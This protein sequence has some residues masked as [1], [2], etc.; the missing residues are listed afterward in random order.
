MKHYIFLAFMILFTAQLLTAAVVWNNPVSLCEYNNV[1]FDG[2]G[3]RTSD[4]YT[5]LFWNDTTSNTHRG[6]IQKYSDDMVPQWSQPTIIA[7]VD[8][9]FNIVETSDGNYLI[10]MQVGYPFRAYKLSPQGVHLWGSSGIA[11]VQDSGYTQSTIEVKADYA[12]GAYIFWCFSATSWESQVRL[13]HIDSSGN[14]TMGISGIPMS[15]YNGIAVRPQVMVLTNNQAI[16]SCWI[17]GVTVIRRVNTAGLVQW[18]QN[19]PSNESGNVIL[20]ESVNNSFYL[21]ICNHDSVTINKYNSSGIAIWQNPFIIIRESGYQHFADMV[22]SDLSDDSLILLWQSSNYKMYFQ[23]LN[24]T[25][26]PLWNPTGAFIQNVPESPAFVDMVR[27]DIGGCYL[28]Y[29]INTA[30]G[31]LLHSFYVSSGGAMLPRHSLIP[32]L[33]GSNFLM[34]YYA[35]KVFFYFQDLRNG[36]GGIYYQCTNAQGTLLVDEN[37]A[38]IVV[39]NYGYVVSTIVVPK[40]QGAVAIWLCSDVLSSASDTNY[41]YYQSVDSDGNLQFAEGPRLMVSNGSHQIS[42]LKGLT[43]SEGNTL[44]AW[45]ESDTHRLKA[46]LLD[47]NCNPLWEPNGKTVCQAGLYDSNFYVSYENNAFY[48]VWSSRDSNNRYRVYGQKYINGTAQWPTQG[49]GLKLTYDNPADITLNHYLA[50][51]YKGYIIFSDQIYT[52]RNLY[53]LLIDENGACLP[54]FNQYGNQLAQFPSQLHGLNFLSCFEYQ[55][56]LLVLFYYY[57]EEWDYSSGYSYTYYYRVQQINSDGIQLLGPTGHELPNPMALIESNNNLYGYYDGHYYLTFYPLN[58]DFNYTMNYTYNFQNTG[59]VIYNLKAL[60]N[61]SLLVIARLF[62]DG[63]FQARLVY[64]YFDSDNNFITPADAELAVSGS[65]FNLASCV[66]N[67]RIYVAWSEGQDLYTNIKLQQLTD[68]GVANDDSYLS[69]TSLIT[70]HTNYPNPFNDKTTIS[71]DLKNPLTCD[72]S[73]YNIKGQFVKSIHKGLLDKGKHV[74]EWDGKDN[75][76]NDT[77]SGIYFYRV[78]DGN[79][80][81]TK[82]MIRMN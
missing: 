24:S 2:N 70:L 81:Y 42:R 73:I 51:F 28:A 44:V 75:H 39:G 56:S 34:T 11:V 82:K 49:Q 10:L 17:D 30:N 21:S 58:S 38:A 1:S 16:I 25:G 18:T 3:L 67:N 15:N 77:T 76:G 55:N 20:S 14:G 69:P 65:I 63:S 53:V 80:V 35:D 9:K 40:Q 78:T 72:V 71:F 5:L 41:I 74:Y 59:S 13:Q 60:Q 12:G 48:F 66:N 22:K 52:N 54:Q 37:N 33:Q 46:Q 6:Y 32:S 45:Y 64:F 47:L 50:A 57:E 29:S 68:G 26:Q 31:W 62:G 36:N 4:G 7:S 43:T 23:K 8:F 61:G 27:D 19:I 79:N